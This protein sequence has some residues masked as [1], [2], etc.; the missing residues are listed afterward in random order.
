MTLV[1][2]GTSPNSIRSLYAKIGSRIVTNKRTVNPHDLT[3]TLT[4]LPRTAPLVCGGDTI[5]VMADFSQTAAGTSH[6]VT[7]ELPTD[8]ISDEGTVGVPTQG[9]WIEVGTQQNAA[10]SPSTESLG[11]PCS[12]D[13]SASCDSLSTPIMISGT[14][15]GS[16][17]ILTF[18]TPLSDASSPS[19]S[20]FSV[21]E[22]EYGMVP[23]FPVVNTVAVSGNRIELSLATP[24]CAEEPVTITSQPTAGVTSVS[25]SPI[26][27]LSAFALTNLTPPSTRDDDGC[28]PLLPL[29]GE[30]MSQRLR[31]QA[32]DVYNRYNATHRAQNSSASAPR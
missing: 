32:L 6:R 22:L 14:I 28:R 16:S 4:F 3:A 27:V 5:S 21:R 15:H 8:I 11:P 19:P 31:R 1:Y 20:A 12:A 10:P 2:E 17:I 9:A 29:R 18:S 7:V 30:R 13:G 26:P 25:G 24:V 23:F